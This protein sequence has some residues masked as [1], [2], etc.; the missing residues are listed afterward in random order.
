M[1]K[2]LV[3][4]TTNAGSTEEVA[5]VV[6]EEIC[7]AGHAADVR[8]LAE[9]DSLTRYDGVIVGA[10]MILGWSR[11]AQR[12]VRRH[13]RDMAGKRVAYFCTLM[14]LTQTN[15]DTVGGVPVAI[16]PL[17]PA[18]PKNPGR[19]GIKEAYAT[20]NNYLRPALRAAPS[21]KPV[22]IAMFGGKLEMF[23]LKW[24]QALFVM[25]IIQAR[26]GDLRNW[27]FIRSWARG[28]QLE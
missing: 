10:P 24:W 9:V 4:Y 11:D 2:I 6:A 21:V 15:Q 13:Q 18:P 7:R 14:S 8:R 20:L 22:S 28:L 17:L 16:D 3:A 25:V 12:F 26:P 27:D 23:R 5:Q 1:K 19:L